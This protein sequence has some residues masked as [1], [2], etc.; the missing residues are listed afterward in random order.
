M[1]SDIELISFTAY[2]ENAENGNR[3]NLVNIPGNPEDMEVEL[4]LNSLME[5][6]LHFIFT[7][8]KKTTFVV[9]SLS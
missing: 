3:V 2:V 9:T 1:S 4:K 6:F 8:I 7:D 5:I